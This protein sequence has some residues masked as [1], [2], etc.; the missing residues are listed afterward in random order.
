M[1]HI[2]P[3]PKKRHK[4]HLNHLPRHGYHK[5]SDKSHKKVHSLEIWPCQTRDK[6]RCQQCH[7]AGCW[8]FYMNCWSLLPLSQC[9]RLV[10]WF[11]M[12]TLVTHI[13]RCIGMAFYVDA[14]CDTSPLPREHI[15]GIG[16]EFPQKW[17]KMFTQ[18][19]GQG[20]HQ[21]QSIVFVRWCVFDPLLIQK[22]RLAR[23]LETSCSVQGKVAG[24]MGARCFRAYHPHIWCLDP[25]RQCLAGIAIYTSFDE[26]GLWKGAVFTSSSLNLKTPHDLS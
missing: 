14:M 26:E 7:G 8:P 23:L 2:C 22:W 20:F 11:A 16:K 1:F 19:I 9:F 12:R 13:C 6:F 10:Y 15:P 17:H 25:H 21:C 24:R 18:S 3:Y 5:V 4:N